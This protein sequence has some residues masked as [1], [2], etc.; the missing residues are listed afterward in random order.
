MSVEFVS[1]PES[2]AA[3]A[4]AATAATRVDEGPWC[5]IMDCMRPLVIGKIALAFSVL[6]CG[7]ALAQCATT[8]GP[9]DGI[10]GVGPDLWGSSVY[11]ITNWDADGP[12]PLPSKVVVAGD[13]LVAGSALANRIAAWDPSTGTWSALGAGLDGPV[14]ALTTLPNG[15]L[16]AGGAFT[17]A[18]GVSAAYVARW[19]GNAWSAL[20]AGTNQLVLALTTLPNGDVLAG[21][22]FTMAGGISANGIARWNGS[23]WSALGAGVTGQWSPAVHCLTTLANGD[24]IAGGSF[25]T[26]G[27]VSASG[28]ARWDG[29]SWSAVGRSQWW[30]IR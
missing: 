5:G 8:W 28:V 2:A 9:G 21:G 4:A 25:D 15:D 10:P 20:G 24:V 23:A 26:A 12:G 18:G 22:Q 29:S 19:N 3:M 11:A 14:W 17:T 1:P 13:F 16:I 27:A 30:N 7:S 6:V